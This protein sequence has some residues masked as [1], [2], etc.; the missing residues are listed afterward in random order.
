MKEFRKAIC[1]FDPNCSTFNIE[2][3]IEII[4]ET[5][6]SP[7]MFVIDLKNFPKN[8]THAMH[9]HELGNLT[10]GCHSTGGHYNPHKEKHGSRYIQGA[11][12]HAGDLINN[13]ESDG[14]GK[15]RICFED[16]LVKLSGKYSVIG[17]TI[18]IHSGIDD[19]GIGGIDDKG[20]IVDEKEHKESTKT[21][22]AGGRMACAIIGINS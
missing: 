9:I 6:R 18:V 12:R 15:V 10:N 7:T 11:K 4:Q 3:T 13:I 1:Y 5:D 22:N 20:Y 14:H 19:L 8:S 16:N 21:G 17:R 2:G